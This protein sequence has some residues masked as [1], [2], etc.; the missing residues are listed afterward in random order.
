[1]PDTVIDV[2]VPLGRKSG[3]IDDLRGTAAR[4]NHQKVRQPGDRAPIGVTSL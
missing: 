2:N 3:G 4:T 1:M